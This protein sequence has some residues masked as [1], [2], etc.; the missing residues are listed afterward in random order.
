MAQRLAFRPAALACGVALLA[1]G[2]VSCA[3]QSDREAGA[4]RRGSQPAT[5][6]AESRSQRWWQD[7]HNSRKEQA[8]KGDSELIF[9]GDSITMGM[10]LAEDVLEKYWGKY[11]PGIYGIGGDT[12][13][14]VL[15]RLQNGE[16]DGLKP[17]LAVLLIGTNNL[18]QDSDADIVLGV[19][20]DV[21]AMKERL[22][23]TKILI[24]GITPRGYDAH[25][26]VRRRIIA[27]N[28]GLESFADGDK[29][30]Y[31]DAGNKLTMPDGNISAE[32]MPDSLHLSHL[33]YE[34]LFA[35][36]KPEVDRLLAKAN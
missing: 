4:G 17:K 2:L 30:F 21:E 23:G 16:L 15:W 18:G 29:V 12:T 26:E 32:V 34:K 36:I 6:V 14:I 10:S 24:L 5:V 31:L 7:L 22:P 8:R 13:Q 27:I 28:D 35:A 9:V 25:T 1:I 19:K 33:G 11:K 3:R 20:A